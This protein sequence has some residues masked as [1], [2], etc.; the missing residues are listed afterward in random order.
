MA[1]LPIRQNH[2]ARLRLPQ[3][4]RNFQPIFPVVFQASVG[5][6]K[7]MAPGRAQNFPRLF[8]FCGTFGSGASRTG[9][10][11]GQVENGGAQTNGRRLQ[12]CSTAG[13]LHIVTMGCNC[14]NVDGL[15]HAGGPWNMFN[16]V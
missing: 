9:F 12:Q 11:L 10:S 1:C 8:S 16:A 2:D 3:H 5:K 13:L 15:N 4:G 7:G 14:E 6:I